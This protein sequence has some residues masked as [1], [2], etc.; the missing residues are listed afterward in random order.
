MKIKLVFAF[1][2]LCSINCFSQTV[3]A[4]KGII[5]LADNQKIAFNN[6]R[7]E[8]GKFVFFDV[9]SGTETSLS[10][11]EI[12]Y[13]EDERNSKVFTNKTVVDRTR[14]ADLKY[15]A[16][17][18]RLAIEET[19]RKEA[20]FKRKLEE[21]KTALALGL[22]PNGVYLTKED[23]LNK[24]PNNQ[25]ELI[26]KDIEGLEK[27][28]IYG[29]PDQCFFYFLQSDKKVKN[30][31]AVSYRGRLYFQINAILSNRNKTDRSQDNDHPNAFVKVQYYGE[32][33]YYMEAELANIWAQVGAVAAAG[34]VVGGAIAGSMGNGKGVVWDI[35]NKEFNIF[36]NCEDFNDFIKDKYP[37]GIQVCENHQPNMAAV[38]SA[39]EKIK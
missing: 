36:K 8:N 21:E 17:Q 16:E 29:I 5:T 27:E 32:N 23:F 14:E 28:R 12:K 7:L 6:V 26:A 9:K 10:I 2:L 22:F 19:S 25:E 15:E 35:K 24:K 39:I 1:L 30:A 13:I 11:G 33:Y 20:E 34:V 38:R 31:F 4:P 37:A 18:K 3:L